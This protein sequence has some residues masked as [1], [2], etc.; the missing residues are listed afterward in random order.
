MRPQSPQLSPSNP[1]VTLIVRVRP[2][3]ASRMRVIAREL[4]AATRTEDGCLHSLAA[5]SPET[6][7]LFLITSAWRDTAACENHRASPY[8]RAFESQIE[9]EILGEPATARN[10]QKIG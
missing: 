4:A 2:S 1:L 10:W 9:P 7:G 5:E 6:P 3:F 8:V